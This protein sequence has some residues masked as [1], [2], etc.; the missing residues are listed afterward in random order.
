MGKHL[1]L[2]GGGHAHMSTMLHI[3]EVIARGHRAT[4]IGPRPHHYYSGMGPGLLGGTYRPQEV[5][6]NIR[7]MVE[8]RGAAFIQD[9]VVGI[10]G[11][12]RRLYLASGRVISYDVVSFNIGSLIPRDVFPTGH[13]RVI[14]VKPIDRLLTARRMIRSDLAK[15]DVTIVVAGGGAAGV[16]LAGNARRLGEDLP[17][18]PKVTLVAGSAV[19]KRFPA[20]VA[21]LATRAMVR[22]GIQVMTGVRVAT[23][24]PEHVV[25]DDG[26]RVPADYVMLAIGIRPGRLFV[27]SGIPTAGDGGMM[28][29]DTLRSIKFP[30]MFGGGDCI[31]LRSR[32]LA[33]V[34]VYAV[35]QN[36]VLRYNLTAALERRPLR[37]FK[38][39]SSYQL[40][41]NLGDGTAIMSKWALVLDGTL[42]FI[43]KDHIDRKFMRKFQV[44]GELDEP[45]SVEGE[46]QNE[47]A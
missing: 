13:P 9:T 41:L 43:M 31:E 10:A 12:E 17:G 6:F 3:D 4:V 29:E 22:R 42:A 14:P 38:P 45:E 8:T 32:S 1:V 36:P 35:R 21:R 11:D 39:Q 28:V 46:G 2:V 27:D 23:I 40:I 7:K 15:R 47:S 19:L 30:E 34:G 44:S 37:S 24:T 20:K 26:V 18:T 5:R 16:E 33:K 25:L